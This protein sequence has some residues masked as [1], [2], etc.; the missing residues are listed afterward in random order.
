MG[1]I[2][3]LFLNTIKTTYT[4]I[5]LLIIQSKAMKLFSLI[6]CTVIALVCYVQS[7]SR[8]GMISVIYLYYKLTIAMT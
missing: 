3:L 2:V 6:L 4:D 7:F 1:T 8:L 5:K